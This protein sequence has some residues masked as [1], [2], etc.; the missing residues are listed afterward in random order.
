MSDSIYCDGG[1]I[2]K[3]PSPYGGTWAWCRVIGGVKVEHD[4]GTVSPTEVGLPAVTNNL[5]ELLAVVKAM[6]SLPDG[7]DGTLYTDS[8]VTLR[9]VAVPRGRFAGIP[10]DLRGQVVAHRK[11]LPRM[12]LTLVTGHPTKTELAKGVSEKGRPVSQWNVW[13]DAE[14]QRLGLDLL[15]AVQPSVVQ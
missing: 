11:R 8:L 10:D 12:R 14:C 4:S 1:V 3:N 2:R 5:T 7:W 13:C 15:R 6:A 9:R